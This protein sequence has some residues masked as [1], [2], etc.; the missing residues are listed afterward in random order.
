MWEIYVYY[1][2]PAT[3]KTEWIAATREMQRDLATAAKVH[4]SFMV[5]QTEPDLLMEVY[6]QVKDPEAFCRQLD[7]ASSAHQKKVM[8]TLPGRHIEIFR[9]IEEA[10]AV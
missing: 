6:R 2:V 1:R 9:Y 3:G 10:A 7:K 4:C 8:A 5:K